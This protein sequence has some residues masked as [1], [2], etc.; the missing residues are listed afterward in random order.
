MLRWLLRECVRANPLYVLSAALL[1]YGV[2]KL[3]TE[4]DPQV[5]KAGGML[6]GLGLLLLY[7]LCLLCVATV[8]LRQRA[9]RV[10][11]SKEGIGRDC[12]GLSIV[13]GLFFAGSF[14]ALDEPLAQW[15]A[16]GPW[17][18]AAAL[19]LGYGKLLWYSRLPGVRLPPAYRHIA[20][21][22]VAGP[23]FGPLLGAPAVRLALGAPAARSLAWLLGWLALTP[24]L[25]L[26]A[27]EA[28]RPAA[29]KSAVAPDPMA[30]RVMGAW[31]LGI[32]VLA[33]AVHMLARDWVFDY[34]PDYARFLPAAT[35]LLA[36]ALVFLW[37]YADRS[38]GFGMFCAIPAVV[39]QVV[40]LARSPWIGAD[41]L[42]GML[43]LAAQLTLANLVFYLGLAWAT[44][45]HRFLW[46]LSGSVT[47]PAG[48]GLWLYRE[49]I[50]HFQAL[51]ITALGFLTLLAGML[52][53][54]YR[55]YLLRLLEP[56]V[57]TP[58]PLPP[59]AALDAILHPTPTPRP[60]PSA[61]E[62]GSARKPTVPATPEVSSRESGGPATPDE[63]AREA[64]GS[65]KPEM[66]AGESATSAKPDQP[67]REPAAP[68][69]PVE[70]DPETSHPSRPDETARE[71]SDSGNPAKSTREV[72]GPAKPDGSAREASDSAK[73][74]DATPASPSG[75][76]GPAGN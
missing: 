49:S 39:L 76:S 22:L 1:C 70:V 59:S 27:H 38:D 19:A 73:P 34:P 25:V 14:L 3:T 24:L 55:E 61:R 30:T 51:C 12:H 54:L 28:R 15:P 2:L 16:L 68:A 63:S 20:L 45:A 4:I 37:K 65:A 69:R 23:A 67:A 62:T 71:A 33:G 5:G 72:S 11:A 64:S 18:V 40:W 75:P 50:P 35:V 6:L 46:G 21:A 9:R 44:R 42:D 60:S 74:D 7:E 32:C 53:S 57:P 36:V 52:T 56:A 17:A 48:T 29:P 26:A 10:D 41:P 13:A 47:A 66:S 58:P 8:V 43:G 31:L